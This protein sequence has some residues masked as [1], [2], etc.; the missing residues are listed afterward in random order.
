MST[1]SS[2]VDQLNQVLKTLGTPSEETLRRVGSPR[3]QEYI[4]SLPIQRRIPFSTIFPKAN[5]LAIDLLGKLL[6]FDPK[7]RI[8]CVKALEH[9]W[10]EVWH[11]E[12]DEPICEK[13]GSSSYSE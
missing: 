5:P 4:R 9:P 13:V 8:D 1:S 11:D 7:E 10:F 6:V 3:A 12:S 2:Y